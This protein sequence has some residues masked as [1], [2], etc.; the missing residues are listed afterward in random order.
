MLH[1]NDIQ[2]RFYFVE[3]SVRLAAQAASAEP[4]LPRELRNCIEL[5]D[6][7]AD[8]AREILESADDTRIRKLVRD[9]EILAERAK[10]ICDYIPTLSGQLKG[11]VTHMHSQVEELKRDMRV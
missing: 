11:A 1:P 7:H 3:R 5:M 10:R 4:G 2:H 8:S 6:K 9:L